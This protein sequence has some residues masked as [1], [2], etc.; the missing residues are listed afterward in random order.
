M[1][2]RTEPPFP[3]FPGAV[4]ISDLSVYPW[5]TVDGCRGGSPHVHLTCAECYVVTSGS[6]WL[7]TLTADGGAA[8][9]ELG[10]GDVAWFEPGTIHRAVEGEGLRILVIMQNGGLPEAGDAV[11]TFPPEHL[12]DPESYAAAASILDEE[13]RPSP[14]RARARR[15]LAIEGYLAL[16]SRMTQGDAEALREFF[17]RAAAIVAPRLAEWKAKVEADALAVA[18]RTLRQID[19]LAGGDTTY[20]ADAR[21]S[22]IASPGPLTYG[23]CGTLTPYDVVRRGN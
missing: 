12:A 21:V 18:A 20:L 11:M 2:I 10:P 3:P 7:E 22:R 14:D 1:T 15:D 6:G 5:P 19:Q 13:G 16:R 17:A 23:M 8:R 4:G 9:T